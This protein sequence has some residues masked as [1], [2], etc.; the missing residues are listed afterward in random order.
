MKHH[1][2]IMIK[3]HEAWLVMAP[4]NMDAQPLGEEHLRTS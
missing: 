1:V 4:S 2:L 3:Q